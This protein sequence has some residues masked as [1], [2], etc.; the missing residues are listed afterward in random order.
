MS[1][2]L[3]DRPSW[4]VRRAT[5]PPPATLD[6]AHR[7]V[8]RHRLPRPGALDVADALRAESRRG[9]GRRARRARHRLPRLLRD[10]ARSSV[11]Q[12]EGTSTSTSRSA[13]SPRSL[14]DRCSATWSSA[15]STPTP[16]RSR[17]AAREQEIPFYRASSAWCWR[18]QRPDRPHVHRRLHRARRLRGAGQALSRDDARGRS[19]TRSRSGPARPRRR[20]LPHGR[21][22]EAVPQRPRR[23]S[24]TSSATPT[25]ATRAPS[26]TARHVEG[27]PHACSRA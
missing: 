18:E 26:W 19:S 4:R 17:P 14:S 1:L 15:C 27:N 3:A 6:A 2:V 12:P 20:R 16:S 22:W 23:R 7:R 5:L 9:S 21:K 11:S 10:A 13:T 24:S 8:R 25:R